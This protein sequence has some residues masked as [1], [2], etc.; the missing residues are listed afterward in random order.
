MLAG[1]APDVTTALEK[2]GGPA[3]VEWKLDGIRVQVHRDGD[4]VAVFTRSLDDITG[5]VPEIVEV[6]RSLAG[7]R[8]RARR[9]GDPAPGRRPPGAVPGDGVAAPAAARRMRRRGR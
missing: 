4:D 7:T 3:A 1:T 5:R 8:A 9:R 6:V 2:A